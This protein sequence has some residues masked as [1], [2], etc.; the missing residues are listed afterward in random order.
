MLLEF[1]TH[2]QN[3]TVSPQLLIE[4]LH[5]YVKAILSSKGQICRKI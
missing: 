2:N 4:E 5:Y 3:F 1:Q